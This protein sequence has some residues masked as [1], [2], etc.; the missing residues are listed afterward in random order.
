MANRVTNPNTRKTKPASEH[1]DN[2]DLLE[3]P[4]AIQE[5]F[6]NTE[7]FVKKNAKILAAAGILLALIVGGIVGYRYYL[8]NQNATAQEE[9]FQAIYY[10]EGDSLN[11]ALNGDGNN[12]GFLEIIDEFG[13]TDA[14]NL[15]HYYAGAAYLQQGD[16]QSA[17]DHLGEFSASDLLVQARAYALMGDAHMELGDYDQAAQKYLDAANYKSN[18]FFSPQYLVQAALA[19]EA[20]GN[21]SAAAERYQRII[22]EYPTSAQYPE[23]QKQF[24][25]LEILAGNS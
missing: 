24:A 9:M 16:Y 14:A 5:R 13:G 4:E 2:K 25:R 6:S 20:A 3:R 8:S 18:K 15:A 10:F 23:A 7:D 1:H 19:Y 12:Y 22:E 21:Y 17:L 11:L